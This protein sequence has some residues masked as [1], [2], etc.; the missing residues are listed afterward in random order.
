MHYRREIDGLRAVAVA[1]VILFHAGISS[2]SGGFVGVDIFFVLSGYLITSLILKDL[3]EDAFSLARFYER[4][5]RRILPALFLVMFCCL[6]FAW[7]RMNPEDFEIFSKSLITAAFSGSNFY[8]WR[9]ADYFAPDAETSPLLHTWSLGVEE[10]FYLLFPLLLLFLWRRRRSWMAVAVAV[11]AVASLALSQWASS[12]APAMNF[13]LLPTRTWELLA[14]ALVAF[15]QFHGRAAPRAADDVLAAAGLS[16]IVFSIFYFDEGTPFPSVYALVP[17]I[18]TVL[19]LHYARSGGWTARLLSLPLLV[20]LGQI[21]YSAY[22]WHQPVFA[23]LRLSSPALPSSG[24]IFGACGLTLVLAYLSWRLVEQPF[25]KNRVRLV[26]SPRRLSGAVAAGI[27]AFSAFAMAGVYTDGLPWRLPRYIQEFAA[28]TTWSRKCLHQLG[29]DWQFPERDCIYNAGKP[30]KFAIWGDSV[31][32]SITPVLAQRL[33]GNGIELHQLTHGFCAPIPGVSS[34]GTEGARECGKFNRDAYRY[35]I[36]QRI[37]T[38]VLFASW[39]AFFG[40]DRFLVEGTGAIGTASVEEKFHATLRDL[41]RAGLKVILVYPHPSLPV[42]VKSTAIA[43]MLRGDEKPDVEQAYEEF[44]DRTANSYALLDRA[45]AGPGHG[46]LA[47]IYPERAFCNSFEP[48]KCLMMDDGTPF[49][50]DRLH[51][52]NHGARLVV[53]EI[54]RAVEAMRADHATGR[55]DQES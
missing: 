47:R 38:V 34:D 27:L 26:V 30:Q 36:D 14:G 53:D 11:L 25:R 31:S 7:L 23:F 2:W 51:F 22:L 19:V 21:S 41:R 49:I 3:Q 42:S 43:M 4:R 55:T 9:K 8:F 20:G 50:A 46:T 33:A 15:R 13:Y 1:S 17:I 28:D 24:A 5:A 37:D 10:Q 6:P 12:H 35:I 16:L 40:Q 18:G 32:S 39:A 48:G 29:T 45:A 54:M 52:T 44:R